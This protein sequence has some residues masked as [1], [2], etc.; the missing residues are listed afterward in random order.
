MNVADNVDE[1]NNTTMKFRKEFDPEA[2]IMI[3]SKYEFT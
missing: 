2:S 3:T 1:I